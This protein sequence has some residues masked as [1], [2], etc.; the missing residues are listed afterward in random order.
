MELQPI[1]TLRATSD[2]SDLA[3]ATPGETQRNRATRFDDILGQTLAGPLFATWTPPVP[4]NPVNS[5]AGAGSST[6][7]ALDPDA[8]RGGRKRSRR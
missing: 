1:A 5:V 4:V 3:G 7:A 8:R 2:M 6:V